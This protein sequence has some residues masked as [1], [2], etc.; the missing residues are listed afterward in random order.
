[1]QPHRK[2]MS[3]FDRL[4]TFDEA[5]DKLRSGK[6]NAFPVEKISVVDSLNRVCSSDVV[7]SADVPSFNRSAV[8]GYAVIFSDV[9]GASEFNP[10]VLSVKGE[11]E[12][13]ESS[14]KRISAGACYEIY[15]GGQ[16]PEGAD[17]VV[18]AED[19]TRKEGKVEIMR[20]VRKYENVSRIGEDINKGQIII[21][22]GETV[23]AQHLASLIAV[24]LSEIEVFRKARMGIISTGNE[25]LPASGT[26]KNTTQ[27]LLL[28]YFSSGL[29]ETVDLGIVPD[30][31]EALKSV[32]EKH[33]N[34][35]IQILVI[36]GG[37]S[38]GAKDIVP[39]VMTNFGDLVFGGVLIK[40]GRTI[41]VYNASG[42]PVFCVSGLPVAALISL[43]AFLDEFLMSTGGIRTS[44]IRI[45]ARMGERVAN[46]DAK[47][48]YL[49]VKL[50]NTEEGVIAHPLRITGSGIL[51][52]LLNAN[53]IVIIPG[54]VEGLEEGEMVDATVI[55]EVY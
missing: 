16:I 6:W 44:K 17:S 36:T 51:S 8:D 46:R 31:A 40:P 52:S 3:S 27:P 32:I 10:V 29:I 18:M 33:L 9:S 55:G 35:D 26:T 30:E 39:D 50:R 42:S 43:E 41:A 47:R 20:P 45:R 23:H 53:G 28:N 2:R 19:A 5:V 7:S 11:I 37:T 13:G 24:G 54:N 22:K 21:R 15:T 12:A 25:I 4:V 38:L 49:R 14:G 1:M 34:I 48:A